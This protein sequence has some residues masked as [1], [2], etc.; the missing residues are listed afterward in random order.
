MKFQ[1]NKF[2][3]DQNPNWPLSCHESDNNAKGLPVLGSW[4]GREYFQIHSAVHCDRLCQ[5][6]SNLQLGT[7]LET[8]AQNNMFF[9]ACPPYDVIRST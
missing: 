4:D 2:G 3:S 7:N 9:K 8:T 6:W 5:L 1:T